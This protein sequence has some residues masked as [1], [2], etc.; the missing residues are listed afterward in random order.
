MI[1][2]IRLCLIALMLLAPAASMAAPC[3]MKPSEPPCHQ[4]VEKPKACKH[5]SVADCAAPQMS[6]ASD[7][8]QLAKGQIIGVEYALP[9]T[10]KTPNR[11]QP[12]M[13]VMTHGPPTSNAEFLSILL[14][15]QRYLI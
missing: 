4:S 8:P 15:T 2:F 7:A 6:S 10:S 14:T 12:L 13:E 1:C 9:V 3:W 11:V 5:I